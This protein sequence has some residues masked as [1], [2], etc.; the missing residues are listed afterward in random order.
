M[1]ISRSHCGTPRVSRSSE[2]KWMIKGRPPLQQGTVDEKSSAIALRGQ[3]VSKKSMETEQISF[4]HLPA[5]VGANLLTIVPGKKQL[6]LFIVSNHSQFY[7]NHHCRTGR[8]GWHMKKRKEELCL[9][10]SSCHPGK[11]VTAGLTLETLIRFL[12]EIIIFGNRL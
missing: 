6:L 5:P 9:H 12:R 4:K 2:K 10:S 1:D 3:G 7:W 11:M 8:G